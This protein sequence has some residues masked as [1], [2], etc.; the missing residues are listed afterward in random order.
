MMLFGSYA[1]GEPTFDSDVDVCVIVD[2]LTQKERGETFELVAEASHDVPISPLVWS[3]AELQHRL[4]RERAIAQDI[5]Q[6]GIRL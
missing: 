4:D 2:D 5:T 6:R 1:W 3:S